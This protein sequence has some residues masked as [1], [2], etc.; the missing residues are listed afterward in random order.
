MASVK[1]APKYQNIIK[2]NKHSRQFIALLHNSVPQARCP[3]TNNFQP[4]DQTRLQQNQENH[5]QEEFSKAIENV[6][7]PA[8][9]TTAILAEKEHPSPSD[10][11]SHFTIIFEDDDGKLAKEWED[12]EE[13]VSGSTLLVNLGFGPSSMCF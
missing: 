4:N 7:I 3:P 13:Y 11:K 5:S 10:N 8:G 6:D 1:K 9:A 12:M 2:E